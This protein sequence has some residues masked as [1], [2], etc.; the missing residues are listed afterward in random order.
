MSK[1]SRTSAA[2]GGVPASAAAPSLWATHFPHWL[3]WEA[4]L[5]SSDYAPVRPLS[6]GV[7]GEVVLATPAGDPASF[8]ALKLQGFCGAEKAITE[9]I[10]KRV[11]RDGGGREQQRGGDAVAQQ[12]RPAA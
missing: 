1:R 7:Y 11:Q 12:Q 9:S 6:S 3:P 4:A 5:V 8:V 10:A 2:S